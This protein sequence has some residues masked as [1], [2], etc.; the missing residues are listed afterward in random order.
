MKLLPSL[1][2]VIVNWNSKH[3]LKSCLQSVSTAHQNNF[4]ISQVTIV[5]NASIDNSLS[6]IEK[7]NLPLKIIKNGK[8]VGFGAACNQGELT[9]DAKYVLFLNPDTRINRD[10]LELAIEFMETPDNHKTGVVGIQLFNEEN[11]IQKSCSRFPTPTNFWCDL[12]GISKLA[13]NKFTSHL[14]LEWDHNETK[15][16][17]HVIGAFYLIR[18]KLFRSLNGF[19]EDYF[20]YLEDLDLSCRVKKSGWSSY[21]LTQCQSFHQGGGTS[22]QVK[23]T[24]LFY[25]LNSKIIYAHKH[26][27]KINAVVL[28]L[29]ILFVEPLT[30][31]SFA[32]LKGSSEE[33]SNTVDG[34]KLLFN[35][36]IKPRKNN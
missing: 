14:M 21:Y 18:N 17:D 33:L 35:H 31:I 16:V 32:I 3:Y 15:E 28:S 9:N 12:I 8:N 4:Q 10:S 24:R 11:K 5:D 20:V 29:G 1:H 6:G 27:N 2:I 25:S 19:D 34:Y 36:L 30:R 13:T 22:S 26:F 23:A 7:I